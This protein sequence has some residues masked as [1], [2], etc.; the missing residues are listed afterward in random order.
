M[1]REQ[2]MAERVYAARRDPDLT[3]DFI[4]QYLPFIKAETT[5]FLKRACDDQDDE[6]SIAIGVSN[7]VLSVRNSYK[8]CHRT[9]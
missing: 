9:R 5:R 2:D 1:H 4:Y 6:L 7:E 3:D 8:V